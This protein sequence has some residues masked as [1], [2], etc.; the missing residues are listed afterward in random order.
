VVEGY[1]DMVALL[2]DKGANRN[3][4]TYQSKYPTSMLNAFEM[5]R[6]YME[7]TKNKPEDRSKIYNR[8]ESDALSE[9]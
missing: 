7:N 9:L 3:I 8:F 1:P 2:L 6:Y 4:R 5:A